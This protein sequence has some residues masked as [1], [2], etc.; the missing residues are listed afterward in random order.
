MALV[1]RVEKIIK[2][3][4]SIEQLSMWEQP[5]AAKALL[6]DEVVPVLLELAKAVD[7]LNQAPEAENAIDLVDLLT[8]MQGQIKALEKRVTELQ[9]PATKKPVP[10]KA[11]A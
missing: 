11:S 8:G 4:E 9:K 10:A 7:E 6:K 2:K 1:E 5:K 3:A